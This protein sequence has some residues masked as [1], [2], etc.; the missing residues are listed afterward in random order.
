MTK[1]PTEPTGEQFKASPE[2]G[3]AF[4]RISI[5]TVLDFLR[6]PDMLDSKEADDIQ[7][8]LGL[9]ESYFNEG[10]QL[11]LWQSFIEA[12]KQASSAQ[13]DLWLS[14]AVADKYAEISTMIYADHVHAVADEMQTINAFLSAYP[15]LVTKDIEGE[16]VLS[17]VESTHQDLT[18][19]QI[20]ANGAPVRQTATWNND[21]QTEI[22][23]GETQLYVDMTVLPDSFSYE[24]NR[25][26]TLYGVDLTN[27]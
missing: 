8:Y 1:Q 10:P 4:G 7:L 23:P 11:M 18:D 22:T 3:F 6:S 9:T 13:A 12:K 19:S 16:V 2:L 25:Y 26:R 27:S 20:Q 14:K 21:T 5:D 17:S 24:L 15:G